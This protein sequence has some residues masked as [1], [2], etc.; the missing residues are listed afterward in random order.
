MENS[1]STGPEQRAVR[2]GHAVRKTEVCGD[3][4]QGDQGQYKNT[5]YCEYDFLKQHMIR[6]DPPYTQPFDHK[7]TSLSL[8]LGNAVS[9]TIP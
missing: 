5:D 8:S 9:T 7:S 2:Q 3:G 6:P 1:Q 4:G